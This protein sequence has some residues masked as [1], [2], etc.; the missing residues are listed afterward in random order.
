MKLRHDQ[1]SISS[2]VKG[3]SI[4]SGPAS[5]TFRLPVISK[6]ALYFTYSYFVGFDGVF[7]RRIR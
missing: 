4:S 6:L 7:N 1:I 2:L 5:V 3:S